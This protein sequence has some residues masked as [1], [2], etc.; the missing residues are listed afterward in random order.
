MPLDHEVEYIP[1]LPLPS[2]AGPKAQVKP[3]VDEATYKKMHKQ[4][5]EEPDKFWDQVCISIG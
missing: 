2:R 3:H 1:K 4:S 5:L